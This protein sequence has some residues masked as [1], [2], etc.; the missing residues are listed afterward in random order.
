M[1]KVVISLGGSVLIPDDD[2]RFLKEIASLLS[3]LSEEYE[4]IAVC[5]GGRI[6]R[7]Y[8]R[9]GTPPPPPPHKIS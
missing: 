8:I 1:D 7:Y 6:S 5:G 2:V 3:R 4:L 9:G